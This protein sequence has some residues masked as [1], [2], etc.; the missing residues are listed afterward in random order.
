[1]AVTILYISTRWPWP[2]EMGRQRM[3]AQTLDFAAELGDVHLLSFG[4]AP[5]KPP[6]DHIRSSSMLRMSGFAGLVV[7]ML[8]RP[9]LPLQSHLFLNRDATGNVMA[10]V[11]RLRPQVIVFD[12]ARLSHLAGAIRR[13]YPGIRLVLDMDDRLSKRYQRMLDSET[14][15]DLGGT[16]ESRMPGAVR[17]F[18]PKLKRLLLGLEQRLMVRAEKQAANVFDAILMVSAL[19]ADEMRADCPGKARVIAFPPLINDLAV[20]DQDFSESVRFVFIGNAV[21]APNTEALELLDRVAVNVAHGAGEGAAAFRFQ[22][23]G[24][25]HPDAAYQALEVAGFVPDLAEFLSGDAVLAA[26]IL[27]GT[28]IKTKIIDALEHSVPVITTPVGAEGLGLCEGEHYIGVEG[29]ADL[30]RTCMEIVH[31]SQ[32]RGRL[33]DMAAS[34]RNKGLTTQNRTILRDRLAAAFGL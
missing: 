31:S 32:V 22:A 7:S 19:E 26:P 27:Q 23:A 8:F 5:K 18:L 15:G 14:V 10:A 21:Y 6:P 16:F 20:P 17:F 25:P 24:K 4:D 28:G 13:R 3:I 30:T 9:L 2:I 12:M 11:E 29:E 1:M 34:A 33:A